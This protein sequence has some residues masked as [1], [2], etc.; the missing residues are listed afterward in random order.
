MIKVH[1]FQ[2]LES[3]L[4]QQCIVCRMFFG[5]DDRDIVCDIG[6]AP[7]PDKSVGL[8]FE[9]TFNILWTGRLESKIE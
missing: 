3:Q 8:R 5:L 6:K 1:S 2:T 7:L 4:G 9:K